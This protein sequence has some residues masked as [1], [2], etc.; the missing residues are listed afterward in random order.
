LDCGDEAAIFQGFVLG[1]GFCGTVFL[2]LVDLDVVDLI[3]AALVL[4]PAD[5]R[6]VLVVLS[7]VE[8]GAD[9]EDVIL[10]KVGAR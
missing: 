8:V 5:D 6:V 3:R 9:C 7:D 10:S 4:E 1:A 2:L